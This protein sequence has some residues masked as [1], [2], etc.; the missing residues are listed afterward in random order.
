M[1]HEPETDWSALADLFPIH[2]SAAKA[3]R[4]QRLNLAR[5]KARATASARGKAKR[6]AA[7]LG[8]EIDDDGYRLA[9]EA[10][11]HHVFEQGLHEVVACY[12]PGGKCEAWMSLHDDMLRGV[13]PCEAH[14]NGTCDWCC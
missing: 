10:P 13:E 7:K 1:K 5:V 11:Q 14:A 3:D 4:E 9:C 6:L 8:C 2:R 12:E